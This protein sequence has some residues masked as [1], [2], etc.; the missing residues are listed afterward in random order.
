MADIL[1][2]NWRVEPKRSRG[3]K[4]FDSAGSSKR[5]DFDVILTYSDIQAELNKHARTLL[6]KVNRV[7]GLYRSIRWTMK[8]REVKSGMREAGN[9]RPAGHRVAQAWVFSVQDERKR[10]RVAGNKKRREE[11]TVYVERKSDLARNALISVTRG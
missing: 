11:A 3:S 9:F 1:V 10:T 2:G 8:P 4:N 6:E 5:G 7:Y